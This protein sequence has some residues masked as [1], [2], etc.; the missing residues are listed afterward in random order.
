MGI[1]RHDCIVLTSGLD[2]GL[3]SVKIQAR[4]LGLPVTSTITTANG[5]S[6]FLICPD[7]GKEGHSI[8]EEG[9]KARKSLIAWLKEFKPEINWV[10]VA[11][12]G[13]IGSTIVMGSSDAN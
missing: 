9:D 1:V 13:D 12:G 6:S 5:V 11:Y 10:H 4:R 8:S 2:D 7:G 3:V